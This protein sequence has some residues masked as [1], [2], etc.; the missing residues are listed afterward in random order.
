MILK[1]LEVRIFINPIFK[2]KNLKNGIDYEFTI[3]SRPLD[4]FK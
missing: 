4:G 1:S 2:K 3:L